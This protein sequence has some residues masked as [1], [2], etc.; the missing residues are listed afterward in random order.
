MGRA[1]IYRHAFIRTFTLSRVNLHCSLH[2]LQ[3]Q[4][5]IGSLI[6]ECKSLELGSDLT[7]VRYVL[8]SLESRDTL[9]FF[10]Y[11]TPRI[12]PALFP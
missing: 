2:I 7:Q 9:C 4:Q 8:R 6:S 10:A 11:H 3:A 1:P 5:L 12:A